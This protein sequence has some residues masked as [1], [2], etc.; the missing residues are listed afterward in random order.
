MKDLLYL[1]WRY[2][3]YHRI[4]TAVL[5][6]SMT[7]IV[8]LPAGLNLLIGESA[9]ELTA[10]AEA[11]PLLIGAKGSPLELVLN[12]LY[13]D[14][15]TPPTLRYAEAARIQQSGLADA[16]PIDAR[17][18]TR[19]SPIVGTTIDYF[20]FRGLQVAEGRR[21]HRLG[22][23]VL[24]SRAA[25]L[26]RAGPG[27]ALM[28]KPEN[29]FDIAGVYPLKMHVVGVLHPTGTPDDHGVFVDTKT[30]WVIEGRA[31]GHAD[32]DQPAEQ[33][34]VLRREG[35]TIVANASVIQYNEITAENIESFHFH[36]DPESFPITAVLAVPHDD[37]SS[38]L[39]QG[40][41]LGDQ[42]LVQVVVPAGV[43]RELL[44]TVMTVQ[45]Y[46][47][48]GGIVLGGATLATMA[49]VFTLSLQ[50]RRREMDTLVKIGGTRLR[51]GAL[52]ATEILSVLG[53]GIVLAGGLSLATGWLAPLATRLLLQLS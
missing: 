42:E 35:D 43:M 34:N 41:Y 48:L 32:L 49:L 4:K 18:R 27:D 36:G 53:A 8:Y 2:L 17:F 47:V 44:A 37:K 33:A 12:S 10:R 28:S 16:I 45:R 7:M 5:V 29:V 21:F 1:A 40:R 19:H 6:A 46:F 38:T 26:A 14:G 13:F 24:G 51:L 23:C 3:A 15:D 9:D 25:Q 31:H 50:L 30:A 39:L 22:E 11:T 20:S 52:I